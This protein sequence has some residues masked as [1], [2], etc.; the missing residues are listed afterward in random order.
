MRIIPVFKSFPCSPSSHS[1]V[2]GD[3]DE[4]YLQRLELSG[5]GANRRATQK[6]SLLNDRAIVTV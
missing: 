3:I 1:Y 2:T 6:V 5:R 4:A